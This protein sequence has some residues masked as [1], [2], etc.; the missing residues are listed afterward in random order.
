MALFITKIQPVVTL[1]KSEECLLNDK[2]RMPLLSPHW[3]RKFRIFDPPLG[4][5]PEPIQCCRP[6]LMVIVQRCNSPS[7]TQ[8]QKRLCCIQK[9]VKQNRPAKTG[10]ALASYYYSP[11]TT[12]SRVLPIPTLLKQICTTGQNTNLHVFLNCTQKKRRLF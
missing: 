8:L 6:K 5:Y 4:I 9:P 10:N 1:P 7:T 2:R 3:N 11:P 12:E